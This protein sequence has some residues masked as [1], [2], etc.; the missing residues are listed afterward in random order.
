MTFRDGELLSLKNDIIAG[1]QNLDDA[2]SA[3]NRLFNP[4]EQVLLLISGQETRIVLGNAIHDNRSTGV[5]AQFVTDPSCIYD[6]ATQRFFV[7][8]LTLE[9]HPNGSFT[10]VN[11]LDLAV[12]QTSNPTGGWNIYRID[13]GESL[14]NGEYSLTPEGSNQVFCFQVY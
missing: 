5:R 1:G 4:S 10:L 13:V 8:V 2:R 9:T 6:A 12:S 7:V 11:H 3:A 14:E